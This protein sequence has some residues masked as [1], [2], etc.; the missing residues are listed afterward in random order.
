M[1]ECSRVLYGKKYTVREDI[2]Y[3]LFVDDVLVRASYSLDNIR[4][5]VF[6][7][8][9]KRLYEVSLGQVVLK[10]EIIECYYK[11]ELFISCFKQELEK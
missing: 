5:E 4:G 8:L 6:E 11:T 2:A 7:S 10:S 9:L 1:K 3:E